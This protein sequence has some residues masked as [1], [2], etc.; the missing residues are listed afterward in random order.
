MGYP[1]TRVLS[2]QDS[3]VWLKK[4]SVEL[5]AVT[6]VLKAHSTEHHQFMTWWTSNLFHTL[7][8]FYRVH[9][10]IWIKIEIETKI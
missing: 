1:Q 7:S 2:L 8:E 6:R 5:I 9:N 10:Q 3:S 4:L